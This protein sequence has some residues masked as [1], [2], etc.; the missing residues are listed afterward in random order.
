MF[1][2][3]RMPCCKLVFL[4][5]IAETILAWL[6]STICIDRFRSCHFIITFVFRIIIWALNMAQRSSLILSVV[7]IMNQFLVVNTLS[8][9][10]FY[11][12]DILAEC[13]ICYLIW[14]FQGTSVFIMILANFWMSTISRV[15]YFQ[16]WGVVL[17]IELLHRWTFYLT[18]KAFILHK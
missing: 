6:R 2:L 1:W 7:E 10:C 3:R 17:Y 13:Y 16:I 11:R 9:S 4:K 5:R 14:S 12:W 18:I 8:R 15:L